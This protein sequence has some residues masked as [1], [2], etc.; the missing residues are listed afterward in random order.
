[1][2]PRRV[3]LRTAMVA[4][5]R[6]RKKVRVKVL[7]PWMRRKSLERRMAKEEWIMKSQT[8]RKWMQLKWRRKLWR[9][10]L[11]RNLNQR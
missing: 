5:T 1:M 9:Q 7:L 2:N 8:L 10:M 11:R 4:F 6:K 3:K